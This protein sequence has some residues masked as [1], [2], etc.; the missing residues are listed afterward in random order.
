MNSNAAISVDH[1]S[2]SYGSFRAVDDLSF[3]VYRGEIFAMLGPNGAG[4][5]TTMRM[6]LDILKPDTGQI[7][8]LG[9]PLTESTKDRIGYLPEE[10]GLYRNVRVL[11]MMVY[12]GTLKGMSRANAQQSSLALLERLGMADQAKKKVSE[13][14]KGMQQKIQFGVTVLHQPD[15]IIIDEPFSGLDPVNSLVLK[16][17][18][19]DFKNRGGTIV[20]STHQMAQVEEMCDRLLMIN[21]GQQKLYGAVETIRQQYAL[22]AVIVEGQGQWASLPGVSKVEPLQNGRKAVLL[23][24][25]PQATADHILAA[26]AA[27]P[28]MHIERFEMAVPDL[29][30][31]FIRVVEG[32]QA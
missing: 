14:S 5:S 31:I 21:R 17:L 18:L 25:E 16:D 7:T 1:I 11:E 6:I 22:H 32:A 19:F 13:L 27:S 8:V 20:M 2:K 26:I 23:H 9:G 3:E 4:K 30:D 15:L 28:D 10:R 12:L 29:N 24:L